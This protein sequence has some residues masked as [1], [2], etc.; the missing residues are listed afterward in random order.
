MNIVGNSDSHVQ[1]TNIFTKYPSFNI[2]PDKTTF[3]LSL[4]NKYRMS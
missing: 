4:N 3:Q 2:L 1:I